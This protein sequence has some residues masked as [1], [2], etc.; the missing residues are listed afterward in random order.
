MPVGLVNGTVY[1]GGR[2]P[3]L[4]AAPALG[5]VEARMRGRSF[6]HDLG[7]LLRLATDGVVLDGLDA[8]VA[9]DPARVVC[10]SRIDRLES[11]G[12]VSLVIT[13]TPLRHDVEEVQRW[14]NRRTA[15]ARHAQE[16]DRL[17]AD[18]LS[19]DHRNEPPDPGPAGI[20]AIRDG[21]REPR[22]P[23]LVLELRR[24]ADVD[25]VEEWVR[26]VWPV[27]TV[28]DWHIP[29]GLAR[30]VDTWADRCRA[31]HTGLT[32]LQDLLR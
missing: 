8:L 7:G 14:I 11:R 29:G 26:S 28:E 15:S 3:S 1:R 23:R 18:Y 13:G 16:G 22:V 12:V 19:Q 21:R 4:N 20:A 27:T 10:S 25:V 31:D 17:Y 9:G 30:L 5:L 24:D 2:V 6:P 32:A